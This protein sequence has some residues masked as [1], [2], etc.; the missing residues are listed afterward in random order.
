MKDGKMLCAV[1]GLGHIGCRHVAMIEQNDEMELAAVCDVRPMADCKFPAGT[2]F[3]SSLKELIACHPDVDIVSICVPNGYHADMA[4]ECLE[5]GLSVLVEKPLALSVADAERVGQAEKASK[6]RVFSV[7][8][9]RYTPTSAWVRQLIDEHRLGRLTN[10]VV[11]CMWNR[12]E[13]YY[14]P[15]GW[16]G[17]ADLD[18]GT[19]FTQF[20]HYID[21]LLWL[22]GPIDIV[23]AQFDDFSHAHL[24]DFED[25]GQ[26]LFRT[27]RDGALGTLSFSTAVPQQNLESSLILVGTKGSVKVGGQY[28]SDVDHCAIA[29]YVMP[30]LAPANPPN[31][32]GEY[33]GSAANHCYVFDNVADVLLRG[34]EPTADWADGALVVSTIESIYALRKRSYACSKQLTY[35]P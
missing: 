4:V 7:F 1:V 26:V 2:P 20:S 12:D 15:G 34:A 30:E 25:S 14:K 11:N 17:T 10:V 13:R 18:G 16:H 3:H 19:L 5:A 23:A 32:Y 21:I 8:Q 9:N 6:G 28:M 33:K 22:V 24:T 29:D 35:V 27:R 31:D